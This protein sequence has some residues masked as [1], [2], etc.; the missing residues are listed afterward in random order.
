[1]ARDAG[2]AP[3]VSIAS[4]SPRYRKLLAQNDGSVTITVT[5]PGEGT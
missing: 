4:A 5:T 1:M 3:G 2:K